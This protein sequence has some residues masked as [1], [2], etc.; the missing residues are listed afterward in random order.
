MPKHSA[1]SFET[2]TTKANIDTE[3]LPKELLQSLD[4]SPEKR[5]PRKTNGTKRSPASSDTETR[6]RRSQGAK[7]VE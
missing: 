3:W 6:Q 5:S 1:P 7:L 2:G 4:K